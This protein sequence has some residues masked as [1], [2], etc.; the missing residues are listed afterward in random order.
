[1]RTQFQKLFKQYVLQFAELYYNYKKESETRLKYK[2]RIY[3][4]LDYYKK[5]GKILLS[6][7]DKPGNILPP[8]SLIDVKNTLDLLQELHPVDVNSINDLYYL[9]SDKVAKLV[10]KDNAIEVLTQHGEYKEYCIDDDFNPD[11]IS[12]KR[13][14]YMIGYMQAEKIMRNAYSNQSDKYKIVSDNITTLRILDSDTRDE[15]LK[16]PDEILFTNDY[17]FFSKE[18]ICRIGY[19]CGQMAKMRLVE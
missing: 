6:F 9:S 17:K 11:N 16:T 12:S 4:S 10:V 13:V 8:I 5:T 1:M 3:S 2:Y 7:N 19:I 18:D 15:F 14:A